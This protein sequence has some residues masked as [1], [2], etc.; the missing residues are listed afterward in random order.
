MI[1]NSTAFLF[2]TLGVSSYLC[3]ENVFKVRKF[4]G[5]WP[6]DVLVIVKEAPEEKEKLLFEK[7]MGA[8]SVSR[9]AMLEIRDQSHAD[10]ILKQ[11]LEKKLAERFLIFSEELN[12]PVESSLFLR[13]GV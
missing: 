1:Q 10:W 11:L 2:Y 8:L 7:M 13:T 3:P 6:C 5:D 4:H 9:F 12:P